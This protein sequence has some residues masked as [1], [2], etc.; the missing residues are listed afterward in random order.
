MTVYRAASSWD[1]PKS[2]KNTLYVK[3]LS[4]MFM[5]LVNNC[6]LKC[7]VIIMKYED[8]NKNTACQKIQ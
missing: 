5:Y 3:C 6:S 7:I 4:K 2:Q 1:L 8:E